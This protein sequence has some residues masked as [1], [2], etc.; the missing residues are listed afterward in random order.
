M[1]AMLTTGVAHA[2]DV[3]EKT[4]IKVDKLHGS[5]AM[6]TGMGGNI[7][8]SAGEDGIL[9][10]DDQFAPLAEKIAKAL[11]GMGDKPVKYLVNTHYHGDHTGSN[12]YFTEVKSSTIFA[13]DNVRTRLAADE[14][15]SASALP[16]VTYAEGITFHFNNDTIK[17]MHLPAGHTDSDSVIWF[18]Q[19][20]VMHAGDLFFEGLFPY[21][22]LDGG[23]T[24][25]GY[26]ANVKQLISM[27]NDDTQIIPGHGKLSSKTDYE[28][29]LKMLT[30]TADFVKSKKAMGVSLPDLISAGLD[31]K[32]QAWSWEFINEEKWIS[33]LY[34]GQ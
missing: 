2:Q 26:I 25:A 16:V 9:I 8:V 32:W 27:V 18:E 20:N 1:M 4:N 24:I 29:V 19:A 7:G 5:V 17:V 28:L 12:A 31:K 11:D 13:H 6:L 14:K 10:I 21:I 30:E 22:D 3:F 15:V 33:T 23:G 34:K